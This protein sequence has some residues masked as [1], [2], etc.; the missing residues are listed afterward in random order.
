M[1]AE[2]LKSELQ[3]V[4]DNDVVLRKEF[5]D[6][7]RSLSD[8]RNQLIMRDEDC[9]RLQ[10]TIDVLN[11]KLLVLERDNT[12]YKGELTSFKE[13]RG[14]IKEQL[15]AKQEEIDTRLNE[16][17]DLKNDLNS[18]A[19]DYEL[20]I[21]NIK[22][23]AAD[24]L[25]RVSS[26]FS[27]QI[28]ELKSTSFYKESGIK[29]EY[30]NRLSE[31]T[32]QWADKEQSLAFYHEEEIIALTKAHALEVSQAKKGYEEQL[33]SLGNFSQ[34]E[35]AELRS[36]HSSTMALMVDD[37]N[38][39]LEKLEKNYKCENAELLQKLEQQHYELSSS[40][41]RE[42]EDLKNE[43]SLKESIFISG[44]EQQ[45]NDLKSFAYSGTQ[46]MSLNF[47]NQVED[48]KSSHQ[49][50][51][52]EKESHFLLQLENLSSKYEE[53]LSNT[54][55]HSTSQNS[56]L[57]E[58]LGKAQ[59]ENDQFQT[60]IRGLS[61]HLD[62]QATD[63]ESLSL[64]LSNLKNSLNIETQ[65]FSEISTEFE[66]FKQNSSLS[67]SEQV[68]E[69]NN[70]INNLNIA[71]IENLNGLN[72]KIEQLDEE[73]T[74]L[75]TV[76]ESTTNLLGETE[77]SLEFK[78]QELSNASVQIEDLNLKISEIQHS[79]GKKDSEFEKEKTDL[80][81]SFKLA[82]DNKELE[83][84]KLLIE[85]ANVINEIDLAQDKVEAQ[86]A[87][88]AILKSEFDDLKSQ[89]IGKSER[90]KEILANKNFEVTNLEANNAAFTEELSHVKAEM[91]NLREQTL[92]MS[93][94]S[95]EFAALQNAVTL[96]KNE[97][98]NLM[99]DLTQMQTVVAGLNAQLLN[100]NEK[101]IVSESEIS[102]LKSASK[103]EEQEAFIDRLFK[104]IDLLNDQHLALLDEKDQMASQLLKM[105]D[106]VGVLS[107][108]VD[109]EKIDVTG[110]NNHR[111]NVIF[112][113]NSSESDERSHMKEQINDLVREI[114]KCI[115]LLSA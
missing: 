115:A 99:A 97:K 102:S 57:T 53:R 11:T 93:N 106:V 85:N 30:E 33:S 108:Q 32:M 9:K 86:E 45:I 70:Q 91:L 56:K 100:L 87:E 46:E 1:N 78:S 83:Y 79:F 101:L 96:L 7:K 95:E 6:L 71:H 64:Q 75:T 54:L 77:I 50:I 76:F 65:R 112:A 10:V 26:E 49:N 14:S 21:E 55:I 37:Y 15:D 92:S 18:M 40:F 12:N 89:S 4:L 90:F 98:N 114:D 2:S 38:S 111:K 47:Q 52:N 73:F 13:L 48:L 68:N 27:S 104:Q 43:Q 24:E 8:Y 62:S 22:N 31:L 42:V 67:N 3:H 59:F 84:Q 36:S 28:N 41:E 103:T 107:Q 88:I 25:E 110:L 61:I 60:K 39:A 19:A 109:S 34:N 94:N 81:K 20:K 63:I 80:S 69:L 66:N 16:I 17:Q 35:T 74:N 44:Y 105:S 23:V 29:D 113:K 58:E 72:L 51:L 82:F 5:N